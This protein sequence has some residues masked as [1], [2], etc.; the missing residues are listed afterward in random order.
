MSKKTKILIIGVNGYKA[1]EAAFNFNKKADALIIT[2]DGHAFLPK[3][4][5]LAINHANRKG[6]KWQA[7]SRE[8]FEDLDVS[9]I[10][11]AEKVAAEA[12]KQAQKEADEEAHKEAD[13]LA[14]EEEEEQ[15]QAEHESNMAM[16]EEFE[17][18][19]LREKSPEEIKEWAS[20]EKELTLEGETAEDL[21]TELIDKLG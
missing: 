8:E 20:T 16:I 7:L 10:E 5:N 12:A 4:K 18:V 9:E 11:K 6:V 19:N 2:G 14:K 1:A 21:A 13:R 3:A 15:K 17:G